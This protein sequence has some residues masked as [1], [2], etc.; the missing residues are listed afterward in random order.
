MILAIA[1]IVDSQ[2]VIIGYKL[3]DTDIGKTMMAPTDGIIQGL[4]NGMTIENLVI[5]NNNLR[6]SIANTK[7]PIV[8]L[9]NNLV[10]GKNT[11]ILTGLDYDNKLSRV[12]DWN[13]NITELDLF[14]KD[15]YESKHNIIGATVQSYTANVKAIQES[16]IN[17]IFDSNNISYK[18]IIHTSLLN[19]CDDIMYNLHTERFIQQDLHTG[20]FIQHVGLYRYKN[21]KARLYSIYKQRNSLI[22]IA[23]DKTESILIGI[24]KIEANNIWYKC[25]NMVGR[26]KEVSIFE[27][28]EAIKLNKTSNL[29]GRIEISGNTL[30]IESYKDLAY[31]DINRLHEIQEENNKDLEKFIAKSN[32]I[33]N[34]SYE[35]QDNTLFNVK[36]DTTQI[37]TVVI[38]KDIKEL[39]VDVFRYLEIGTLIV[40]SNSLKVNNQRCAIKCKRI[41]CTNNIV[42]ETLI[43]CKDSEIEAVEINEKST[44]KTLLLAIQY[45]K[46][47]EGTLTYRESIKFLG[48]MYNK[49]EEKIKQKIS[50]SESQS[51]RLI[52][53]FVTEI[54]SLKPHLNKKAIL[55][56]IIKLTNRLDEEGLIKNRDPRFIVKNGE[57]LKYLNI[58]E[59]KNINIPDYIEIIDT[60][61]IESLSIDT[62]IIPS[63][64]RNIRSCAIQHCTIENL[65]IEDGL[66]I[67]RDSAF[68]LSK[69]KNKFTVPA[70]VKQIGAN[71][72][73]EKAQAIPVNKSIA[74]GLADNKIKLIDLDLGDLDNTK[75]KVLN[76]TRLRDNTR[77]RLEF[78][79][80]IYDTNN[81]REDLDSFNL[82]NKIVEIKLSKNMHTIHKEM[83]S[84]LRNIRE[85]D[86]PNSVRHIGDSAFY[87]SGITSIKLSNNI[88]T[89]SR[90]TFRE[91]DKLT[92]IYVNCRDIYIPFLSY[93]KYIKVLEIGPDV[94]NLIWL[95]NSDILEISLLKLPRKRID[96]EKIIKCV[97]RIHMCQVYS[98]DLESIEIIKNKDRNIKIIPYD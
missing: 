34:V 6:Y 42:L 90:D 73:G 61:A 85:I 96:C 80:T 81:I 45:K 77:L 87:N 60:Y 8:D 1:S 75:E 22:N 79:D 86:I 19:T 51:L 94:E 11:R 69:I 4:N 25:I 48:L 59:E 71:C 43:K 57:L 17:N 33:G 36:S 66:E 38:H 12:V 24:S 9:K 89:I 97:N 13:A 67:I 14:N 95:I 52:Y 39:A 29:D 74:I 49:L 53:T 64:I 23:E 5:E 2:R 27:L 44:Y 98:Q 35:V 70:S 10:S 91:C 30:M 26:T 54:N 7:Y 55:E 47:K 65:H 46:V 76:T 72:F 40:Q 83:F 62:L 84:G 16:K 63:N 56:T 31:F 92:K 58:T 28:L 3:L 41:M 82:I 20:E 68:Y 21:I 50:I 88:Q 93:T 32:M 15:L 18:K 37:E 78:D